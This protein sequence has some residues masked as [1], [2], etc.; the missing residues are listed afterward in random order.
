MK[1]LSTLNGLHRS[2]HRSLAPFEARAV[3]AAK[4]TKARADTAVQAV[5][6]KN[7]AEP[8]SSAQ[9]AGEF[10]NPPAS[11]APAPP[12]PPQPDSRLDAPCVTRVIE[13]PAEALIRQGLKQAAPPAIA[14]LGDSVPAI[15]D[16]RFVPPITRIDPALRPGVAAHAAAGSG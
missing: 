16:H 5:R 8:P 13:T 1:M 11:P 3:K 12:R 6:A 2:L 7:A 9:P 14:P 15:E 10:Q 4:A